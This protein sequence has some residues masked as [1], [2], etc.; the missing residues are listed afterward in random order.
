MTIGWTTLNLNF[1]YDF[2]LSNL[3]LDN[4]ESLEAY[5]NITNV[6]DRVPDF[7][8]G[9]GAGGINTTFFSG[10]GRQYELGV[11]MRF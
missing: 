8:S 2:G 6:G 1:R 3:G 4:F 5:F 9:N 7:Y 10:M 11:Q